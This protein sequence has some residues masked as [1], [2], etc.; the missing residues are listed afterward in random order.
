M[1][2]ITRLILGVAVAGIGLQSDHADAHSLTENYL[3]TRDR[4]VVEEAAS[5]HAIETEYREMKIK[6]GAAAAENAMISYRQK[7]QQE[8]VELQS[9]L[10]DIVG[11]QDLVGFEHQAKINLKTLAPNIEFGRLDGLIFRSGKDDAQ[12]LVTTDAI[13]ANW[14]STADPG[15]PRDIATALKSELFITFAIGA[16]D[17]RTYEFAE[18]P[19][20]GPTGG[21]MSFAALGTES[22]DETLDP[23]HE[24]Y[25]S[26]HRGST[27]YLLWTKLSQ[28]ISTAPACEAMAQRAMQDLNRR[29]DA[30]QSWL[31]Y[32]R[33]FASHMKDQSFYAAVLQQAQAL[34]NRVPP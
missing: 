14:L 11:Q 26:V 16:P 23:P 13:L 32:R 21:G 10:S 12:A 19:V 1:P 34:V 29:G 18:L 25:A 33:C 20:M 31:A 3:A 22:A 24:I 2:H 17:M 15:V 8:L 30:G 27:I 7:E 6:Y 4:Y 28:K 9:Q 5:F